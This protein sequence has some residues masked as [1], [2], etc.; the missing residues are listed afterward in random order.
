MEPRNGLL[1][2]TT[3]NAGATQADLISDALAWQTSGLATLRAMATQA[4]GGDELALNELAYAA[5]N[6]FQMAT[7]LLEAACKHPAPA[8]E[9]Q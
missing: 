5:L 7:H 9:T 1:C 6:C 3:I 2:G 8:A 4:H